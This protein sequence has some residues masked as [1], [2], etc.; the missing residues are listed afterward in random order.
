VRRVGPGRA[1]D[2]CDSGVAQGRV[3]R[4]SCTLDNVSSRIHF[5]IRTWRVLLVKY[6]DDCECRCEC[7]CSVRLGL[8]PHSLTYLLFVCVGVGVGVGEGMGACVRLGY[9]LT[10]VWHQIWHQTIINYFVCKLCHLQCAFW[11]L[12]TNRKCQNGQCIEPPPVD[13]IPVDLSCKS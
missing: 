8:A 1:R 2:T 6:L 5:V 4:H 10:H 12:L 3:G 13:S 11:W 7:R 9:V